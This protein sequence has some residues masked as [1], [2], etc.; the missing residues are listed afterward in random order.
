MGD[1]QMKKKVLILCMFCL[2]ICAT[3][4][5]A[6][7]IYLQD[8]KSVAGIVVEE[9]TDR[10][11]IST[12]EGEKTIMKPDIGRIIY[13]LPE[14]NLI[15]MGDKYAARREFEKAY[16][17]YEKAHKAN[18]NDKVARDKM[19]YIMGYLFRK[20]EQFKISDIEKRQEFETWPI[21]PK[22][23]MGD[24]EEKLLKQVGIS[25][26]EDEKR[27]KITKV[28]K[29]SPSAKAGLRKGDIIGSIWGK[30]ADYM[31]KDDITRLLVEESIGEAKIAIERDAILKKVPPYTK[32]YTD[33]LGGK[34]DM[35][36]SGLTLIDVKDDGAAKKAGLKKG[37]LILA[38]NGESTRYMPLKEAINLI[39]NRDNKTITLTIRR[40]VTM[41]RGQK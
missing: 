32:N 21:P 14:Q 36:V 27:I 9:Y 30:L 25:I 5:F 24:A 18:P 11:V 39:E 16:F 38:L 37:D 17:Y 31:Q 26:E 22:K 10:V 41:W 20:R 2:A 6:D 12:Y 3:F 13:D 7:T 19:N 23:E 40:E 1:F 34:L 29:G 28:T 4:V 8:G 35:L 15:R 33:L